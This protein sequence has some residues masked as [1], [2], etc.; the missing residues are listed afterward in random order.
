MKTS[1]LLRSFLASVTLAASVAAAADA[2]DSGDER[3]PWQDTP[4]AVQL[5]VDVERR[6]RFPAAVSVGLPVSL[7]SLLRVQTANGTVYLRAHA[8]F[9]E[10]RVLVRE[11]DTG[12]TYLLDLR[13]TIEPGPSGAILIEPGSGRTTASDASRDPGTARYV[14]LTRFAAQ[15]L[16]APLRLI[17]TLPG[18]ARVPVQDEPVDVLPGDA[19]EALPLMAWRAGDLYLTA[20]KL[21]NRSDKPQVLDPRRLRGRW[22]AAAFQHA[23]LLP[24]G[25][26]ADSTALY[27]ISAQSFA[28][29]L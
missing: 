25:H 17:K 22:L 11:L 1:R 27:L 14:T 2:S 23:R 6:V 20:L 29:S 24:E 28:A 5:S 9:A 18:V 12:Q 19:V 15:H 3:I 16:F 10:S 26:V 13:A 8:P 4:I 7:Q 21:Q